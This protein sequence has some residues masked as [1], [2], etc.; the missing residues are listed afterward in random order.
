MFVDSEPK[1]KT[2]SSM[3]SLMPRTVQRTT[4][5]VAAK[6]LPK[7]SIPSSSQMTDADDGNTSGETSNQ[8]P[9]KTNADFQA[10]LRAGK[11]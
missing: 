5:A 10:M 11:K 6:N 8:T 9:M 3:L 2:A 1:R 7:P 4:T